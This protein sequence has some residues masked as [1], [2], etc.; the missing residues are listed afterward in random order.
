MIRKILIPFDF[1]SLS[2]FALDQAISF[3]SQNDVELH[4]YHGKFQKTRD[5]DYD[6]DVHGEAQHQLIEF[7]NNIKK[8]I[9]KYSKVI[10]HL[11]EFYEIEDVKNIVGEMNI[12]LIM[13]GS[14]TKKD[15][16]TYINNS[17]T[18]EIFRNINCPVLVFNSDTKPLNLNEINKIVLPSNFSDEL[19]NS[20][21]SLLRFVKYFNAELDF[22]HITNEDKLEYEAEAK[23]KD[24][25]NFT[26][27]CP[28]ENMGIVWEHPD[29]DIAFGINHTS[30]EMEADLIAVLPHHREYNLDFYD[31]FISEE[32]IFESEIPVLVI[33]QQEEFIKSLFKSIATKHKNTDCFSQHPHS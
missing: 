26:N 18:S 19:I 2:K 32:I 23:K 29:E 22:V 13:I 21:C 33:P 28:K 14:N 27:K 7:E 6:I 11:N 8:S 15:F 31:D 4:I 12:D 20:Y 30:K 17:H 24:I 25:L 5:S 9:T 10:T 16:E 1:S 3:A